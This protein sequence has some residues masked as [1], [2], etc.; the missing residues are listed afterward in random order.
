MVFDNSHKLKRFNITYSTK[1]HS[2]IMKSFY[3]RFRRRARHTLSKGIPHDEN[4]FLDNDVHLFRRSRP[5]TC[6]D[7]V[8]NSKRVLK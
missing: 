6:V 7:N 5:I 8:A 2:D 3:K 1:H 4:F